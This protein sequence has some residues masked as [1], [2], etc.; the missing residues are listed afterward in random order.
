MQNKL[1]IFLLLTFL[2]LPSLAN[3]CL[4]SEA[5]KNPALASNS[6]FWAD[7][8]QL[9]EGGKVTDHQIKFL[10][11]K[12]GGSLVKVTAAP[13]PTA[14]R[15]SSFSI[16]NRAE[17]EIRNLPKNLK[18]ELDE[19]LE[20]AVGPNGLQEIRKNPGRW[21]LEKVEQF[22]KNARTVRLNGGYRILF[23]YTKDG[24]EI[25]RVN[26]GQIHGD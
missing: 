11:E 9:S 21:N 4:L 10:M 14:V 20:L 13:A 1:G 5:L 26:K 2:S 12:H 23:D 7:L 25:R 22:G 24:L 19:F 6:E 15:S 17:R 3:S 16:A 8:S 18:A